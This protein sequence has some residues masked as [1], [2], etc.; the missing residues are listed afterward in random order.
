MEKHNFPS[1]RSQESAIFNSLYLDLQWQPY[2][3]SIIKSKQVFSVLEVQ[4]VNL[5][6]RL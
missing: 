6:S 5:C 2:K 3:V 4:T 1:Q